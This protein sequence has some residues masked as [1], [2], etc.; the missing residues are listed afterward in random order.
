MEALG[1][2][3]TRIF[4]LGGETSEAHCFSYGRKSEVDEPLSDYDV[5]LDSV[6]VVLDR[7]SVVAGNKLYPIFIKLVEEFIKSGSW[8]KR[9]I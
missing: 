2:M 3:V 7:V 8:K 4:E 6:E 5:L 1:P 9:L